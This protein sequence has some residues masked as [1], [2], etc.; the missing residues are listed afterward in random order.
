MLR[1]AFITGN[2]S[3]T[4]M[5]ID[6]NGNSFPLEIEIS[7]ISATNTS[8]KDAL[9]F[10]VISKPGMDE[11][12][13]RVGSIPFEKVNLSVYHLDG[14]SFLQ[15]VVHLQNGQLEERFYI[16]IPGFY[17]FQLSTK[18]EIISTGRFIKM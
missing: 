10:E 13:I 15:R 9:N 18:D 2:Q 7:E 6:A 17:F 12:S 11:V 3:I 4:N 5:V 16:P 1:N 14:R 8:L